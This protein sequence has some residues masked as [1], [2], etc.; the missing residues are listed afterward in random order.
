MALKLKA[1]RSRL[2][3]RG[4]ASPVIHL[5]FPLSP[6]LWPKLFEPLWAFPTTDGLTQRAVDIR[7]WG[8]G[9]PRAGRGWRTPGAR[10]PALGETSALTLLLIPRFSPTRFFFSLFLLFLSLKCG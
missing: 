5:D 3:P 7:P 6:L 2:P 8:T 1:S 10:M 4:S 9:M